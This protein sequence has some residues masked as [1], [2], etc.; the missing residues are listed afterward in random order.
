MS[1]RLI[2]SMN[3]RGQYKAR[4]FRMFPDLRG[5]KRRIKEVEKEKEENPV[6]IFWVVLVIIGSLIVLILQYFQISE[7]IIIFILALIVV[8]VILLGVLMRFLKM[9]FD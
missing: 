3:K 4:P 2:F 5:K 1:S 8:V 6:A 7:D 9:D